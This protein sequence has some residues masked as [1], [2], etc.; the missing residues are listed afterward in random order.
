MIESASITLLDDQLA[1]PAPSPSSRSAATRMRASGERRSCETP[2]S[3]AR[4]CSSASLRCSPSSAARRR[5]ARSRAHRGPG[6]PASRRGRCRR[7][8]GPGATPARRPSGSSAR[9][10]ATTT[11]KRPPRASS[12]RRR[13]SEGCRPP[14]MPGPAADAAAL[15]DAQP[16]HRRVGGVVEPH[17]LHLDAALGQGASQRG[18]AAVVGELDRARRAA[19]RRGSRPR[20]APCAGSA[21]RPKR[22]PARIA[23]AQ[24][25]AKVEAVARSW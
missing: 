18:H 5:A 21:R 10:R 17:L 15:G 25:G 11:A 19:R 20:S 22:R 16:G 1:Q 23:S 12:R 7:S 9:R 2:S 13:Y 6:S 14:T 24:S 3:I 8:A 4:S